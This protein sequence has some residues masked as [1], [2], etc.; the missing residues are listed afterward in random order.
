MHYTCTSDILPIHLGRISG[1]RTFS[2]RVTLQSL[3]DLLS[4]STERSRSCKA[5]SSWASQ[6]ISSILWMVPILSQFSLIL[7]HLVSVRS[8]LAYFPYFE[9]NKSRLMRSRWCAC[10][11]LCVCVS[12]IVA[13]QRLGKSPLI[14]AGQRL[15]K[16]PPIVTRQRLGKK[17]LIVARQ[18]PNRNVTR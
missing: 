7:T 13:R 17:P 14:V 10:V 11:C 6:G 9:K 16:I 8:I 4:N 12:P 2:Y 15:G 1:T 18:R 5:N 3:R